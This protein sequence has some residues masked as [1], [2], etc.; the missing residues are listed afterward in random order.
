MIGPEG[1]RGIKGM[2]HLRFSHIDG[3]LHT[4]FFVPF[5]KLKGKLS[6]FVNVI[7]CLDPARGSRELGTWKTSQRTE[8]Y[9]VDDHCN[10]VENA[11]KNEM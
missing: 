6:P 9:S 3:L 11:T 10:D 1:E 7:V 4:I 5:L 8:V 2:S